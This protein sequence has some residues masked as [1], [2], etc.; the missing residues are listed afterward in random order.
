MP[1][2]FDIHVPFLEPA[3][4]TRNTIKKRAKVGGEMS[5]FCNYFCSTWPNF[6][7]SRWAYGKILF[8][9]QKALHTMF[10]QLC[11]PLVKWN[12]SKAQ[13]TVDI[14][15][16]ALPLNQTKVHRRPFPSPIPWFSCEEVPITWSGWHWRC[17]LH[18]GPWC[19]HFEEARIPMCS[20]QSI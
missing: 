13:M 3:S 10:G 12:T 9:S 7:C 5:L 11:L 20:H 16:P 6:W 17:K 8:I 19:G 14:K 4:A 18:P 2:N 1:A 15:G